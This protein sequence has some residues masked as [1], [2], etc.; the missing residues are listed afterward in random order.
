MK[1]I[2]LFCTF[3]LL[4]N[5]TSFSQ[6]CE[7]DI[8]NIKAQRV[9]FITT[10]LQ[11]SVEEAQSFWPVYN[12]FDEKRQKLMTSKRGKLKNKKNEFEKLTEIEKEKQVDEFIENEL[13]LAQ[14]SKEYHTRFKK[15]L[16]IDKVAELYRSE[17]KF[18]AQLL[19][20]IKETK[21]DK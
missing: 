10:Q 4:Y 8:E 1:K 6:I 20:Q 12:E 11:L 3:A 17:H 15:I 16:P 14:L 18:K 2:I 13:Q 19:K 9:A 7:K 5:L 21:S